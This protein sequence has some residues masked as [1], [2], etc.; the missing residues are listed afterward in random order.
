MRRRDSDAF[1]HFFTNS[2]DLNFQYDIMKMKKE[3]KFKRAGFFFK[4]TG[5]TKR[6]MTKI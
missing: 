3:I 6:N 2:I 1:F 4:Q 5:E